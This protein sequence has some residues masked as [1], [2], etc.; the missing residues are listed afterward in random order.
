MENQ[1]QT[2]STQITVADLDALRSIVD[3]ATQRGAFKGAEL[4][5]VGAVY[6]KLSTFLAD[7]V[8]QAKAAAEDAAETQGE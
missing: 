2:Q 4:T 3:V 6:D 8:A 1:T 5:Q 7:V